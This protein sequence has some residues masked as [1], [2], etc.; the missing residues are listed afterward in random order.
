[1]RSLIGEMS[2]GAGISAMVG[3][4]ILL[5]QYISEIFLG[6]KWIYAGAL[7]CFGIVLIII[8][9]IRIDFY[10]KKDNKKEPKEEKV[11]FCK[12]LFNKIFQQ[13]DKSILGIL[14]LMLSFILLNKYIFEILPSINIW[15]YLA[16]AFLLALFGVKL[17]IKK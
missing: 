5:W 12:Y 9:A 11:N 15:Y 10:E 13:E 1:M 17:L 6:L 16:I 4:F 7:I 2:F 8:G 3:G 14:F